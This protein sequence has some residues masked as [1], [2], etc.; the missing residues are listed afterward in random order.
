MTGVL[1]WVNVTCTF[2][3]RRSRARD[4]CVY[5][6]E[7]PTVDPRGTTR[8]RLAPE[9]PFM[10][11]VVALDAMLRERGHTVE[12]TRLPSGP[13][14]VARRGVGWIGAAD[15]RRDGAADGR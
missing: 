11:S 7:N 8:P 12:V 4:P 6:G 3:Q 10:E 9:I 13:G 15:P 2:F 5:S 14:F 1:P